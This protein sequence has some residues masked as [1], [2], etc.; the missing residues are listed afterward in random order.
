MLF[1][2]LVPVRTLWRLAGGGE[3]LD[4]LLVPADLTSHGVPFPVSPDQGRAGPLGG[5]EQ[6]VREALP[7]QQPRGYVQASGPVPGRAQ[8]LG[9]LVQAGTQIGDLSL[10]VFFALARLP[11][12]GGI[13]LGH[14]EPPGSWISGPGR[15]SCCGTAWFLASPLIRKPAAAGGTGC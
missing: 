14:Q 12:R 13:T 1:R 10:A 11:G 9:L 7:R 2:F 6:D 8:R 5:D 15:R 3:D 4:A